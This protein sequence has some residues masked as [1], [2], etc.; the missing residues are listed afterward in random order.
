MIE[1]NGKSRFC[2]KIEITLVKKVFH[3]VPHAAAM[4]N[5]MLI[6]NVRAANWGRFARKTTLLRIS[7][8]VKGNFGGF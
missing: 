8:R 7:L 1:T 6:I 5:H 4:R 3:A 2:F